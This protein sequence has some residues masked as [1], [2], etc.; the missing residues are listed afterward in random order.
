MKPAKKWEYYFSSAIYIGL[1]IFL[2]VQCS[3][4]KEDYVIQTEYFVCSDDTVEDRAQFVLECIENANPKS[5]EEP[6]DWIGICQRM[7]DSNYCKKEHGFYHRIGT[8][9]IDPYR[10]THSEPCSKADIPEEK[11]ICR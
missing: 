9:F 10:N 11:E 2:I 8:G 5:D 7:A 6:E 4:C 1:L 3:G